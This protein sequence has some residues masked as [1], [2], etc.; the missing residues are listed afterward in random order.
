MREGSVNFYARSHVSQDSD[1]MQAGEEIAR[2]V[3]SAFGSE[4]LKCLL[5]YAT[6][7]HD[8]SELLAG[9]R[10]VVGEDTVVAGCSAQGIMSKGT[11][12]EGG[13]A[14]GAMGLGGDAL[15]VSAAIEHDVQIDGRQKG[16]DL[17]KSVKA[18]LGRSPD[19]FLLLYDPLCGIDVDQVLAGLQ[20]EVK[21]PITG[22]AASQPSGPVA[23]TYQYLGVT[24]TPRAA[25]GIGLCGPFHAELGFCH[26][27][28]PTG[29][30]MTLT[31]ADGNSL[32]E[33]DGRPALDVW[34]EAI[35]AAPN[36]VLNQSQTAALA[37]GVEQKVVVDGHEQSIYLIRA[38]FGFSDKTKGITVQ[39]AIPEGSKILFHH[40]TVDVVREGT[41]AMAQELSRR[42]AGK[43]PW[44]VLG[45]ECGA[46]TA[47]FLGATST[48]EENVELQTAVAPDAPW[49]GLLAWGEVASLGGG[50]TVHNYSYPL[51]VLTS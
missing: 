11:V 48:L 17:A 23:R 20:S 28:V 26:G 49:L 15:A 37:M 42:L 35:G 4:R 31:R 10:K 30:T 39:A 33:L 2:E 44:A 1:S 50:P 6:I 22:G 24:A 5:I 40:R 21:C 16:R 8:H 14:A 34:R 46:R 9:V 36:E 18:R 38:A 3:K 47:P 27:T 29:V 41:V 19:L 25:V 13:F 51:I 45:F 43:T 12:L 7:N 32:L